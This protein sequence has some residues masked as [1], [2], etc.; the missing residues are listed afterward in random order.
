MF[1][2]NDFSLA[3]MHVFSKTMLLYFKSAH[4]N[5]AYSPVSKSI[6][7]FYESLESICFNYILQGKLRKSKQK[8]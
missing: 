4:C 8:Q 6:K 3:Y 7:Q 1:L 2:E 5:T